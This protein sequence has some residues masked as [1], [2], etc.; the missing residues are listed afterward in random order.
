MDQIRRNFHQRDEHKS[1]LL[2]TRVRDDQRR[3]VEYQVIVKQDVQIDQTRPPAEVLL[4]PQFDFELLQV[5]KQRFRLQ[6][7]FRFDDQVEEGGLVFI[8]PGRRLINV[9]TSASTITSGGM[10]L[11]AARRLASRLPR[12][13]PSAM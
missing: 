5:F 1:A 6:F 3:C 8:S 11:I 13:V 4:A 2:Q 9:W 7:G 12:L 10:D